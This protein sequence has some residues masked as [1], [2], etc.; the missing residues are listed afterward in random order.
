AE[1]LSFVNLLNE[2]GSLNKNPRENSRATAPLAGRLPVRSSFLVRHSFS[3]GGSEGGMLE[4][5]LKQNA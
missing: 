4:P 3:E 2:V 1:N 5:V